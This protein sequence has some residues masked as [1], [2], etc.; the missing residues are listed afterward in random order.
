MPWTVNSFANS[1]PTIIIFSH[2]PFCIS[3]EIWPHVPL[4]VERSATSSI[5]L[6]LL[7]K[8]VPWN[9]KTSFPILRIDLI[10]LVDMVAL[11]F[12]DLCD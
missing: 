8:E 11:L 4:P 7:E 3:P 12:K 1:G 5:R 2:S 10:S 6:P 9:Q